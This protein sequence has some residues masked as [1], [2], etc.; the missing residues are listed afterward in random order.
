MK[1]K[2]PKP[3]VPQKVWIQLDERNFPMGVTKLL[4]EAKEWKRADPDG[5][6]IHEYVLV[7]KHGAST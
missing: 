1:T 5:W 2:K 6:S 7:K 4:S 3:P